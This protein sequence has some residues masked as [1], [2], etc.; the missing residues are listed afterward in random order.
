VVAEKSP[1]MNSNQ[2]TLHSAP[3]QTPSPLHMDQL[4]MIPFPYFQKI[5][6]IGLLINASL[7]KFDQFLIKNNSYL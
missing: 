5:D 4:Q 6:P 1:L 2:Q 7:H 3:S